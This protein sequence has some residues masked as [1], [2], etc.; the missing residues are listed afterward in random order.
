M[1]D[2]TVLPSENVGGSVISYTLPTG[3]ALR[4][5]AINGIT[6]AAT[7]TSTTTL[8][9]LLSRPDQIPGHSLVHHVDIFEDRPARHRAANGGRAWRDGI[10]QRA[11]VG[12]GQLW[13]GN[14]MN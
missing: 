5:Q 10:L 11:F 13:T 6:S 8:Y 7:T 4:I 2:N 14:Q 3:T 1:D 9:W 12:A